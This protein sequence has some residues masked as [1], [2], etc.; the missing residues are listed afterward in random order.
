M[1]LILTSLIWLIQSLRFFSQLSTQDQSLKDL[2]V[3]MVNLLPRAFVIGLCFGFFC[4]IV[5][6]V[7]KMVHEKECQAMMGVGGSPFFFAWPGIVLSLILGGVVT[8]LMQGVGPW[9]QKK[10]KNGSFQNSIDPALIMPGVFFHSHGLHLYVHHKSSHDQ[11]QGIFLADER[12]PSHTHVISACQARTVKR[13]HGL[14]IHCTNGSYQSLPAQG[15]PYFGTFDRYVYRII[16]P[17]EKL[18]SLPVQGMSWQELRAK[19][20]LPSHS[21]EYQQRLWIGFLPLITALW[22]FFLLFINDLPNVWSLGLTI[23][24]GSGFYMSV[25]SSRHLTPLCLS[26][27]AGGILLWILKGLWQKKGKPS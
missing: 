17:R 20:H 4:A 23:L 14:E 8:G 10:Q 11:F 21:R 6:N 27:L 5:V 18:P 12:N 15:K 9:L 19:K 1:S 24:I 3:A 26:S 13:A 25:F 16:T 22:G 7:H 2:S